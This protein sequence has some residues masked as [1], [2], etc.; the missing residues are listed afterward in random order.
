MIIRIITALLLAATGLIH[1]YLVFTGTGGILGLMFIAN[2]LAG[3]VLAA[4]LVWLRGRWLGVA[5]LLSFA[6]LVA[7]LVALLLA[8]TVGLFGIFQTWSNPFA[9][10]TVIVE[11]LGIVAATILVL[12]L[13]PREDRTR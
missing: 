3:V 12:T 11:A 13:R 9:T 2:G 10:A 4:A 5:A 6:F 8:L 1:I 7:S